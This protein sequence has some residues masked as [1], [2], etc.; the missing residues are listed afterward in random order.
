MPKQDI[1]SLIATLSVRDRLPR[2]EE[3]VLRAL[4]WRTRTVPAQSEIITD[5]SSPDESCLL[6]DGLAARAM[7]LRNGDR[8]ITTLH[9]LGDFVDLHS[10][11]LSVMDHSVVALTQCR[12]AF[13]GHNRLREI[14]T[15]H[16]HLG[17]LLSMMVATDAAIQRN[18][19]LSL[20]RRRAES[21]LANLFCELYRR[22]EV[23]GAVDGASFPL[24]INQST[25]ADVL[26]LSIVHTN[27]TVQHLRA[28]NLI[29]WQGGTIAIHDW[30]GLVE[31]AEFDPVYLNLDLA[32]R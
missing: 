13:I 28:T 9:V 5:R 1:D 3:A 4:D 22:L 17:R 24:P 31:L 7:S 20:G 2:D 25:L 6:L 18:W 23:V 19:I 14:S 21:R 27:R 29:S 8:Q 11:F 15:E 32:E 26:G 30:D 16:P 12:V 10:M